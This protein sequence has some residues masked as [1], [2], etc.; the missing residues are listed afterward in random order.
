MPYCHRMATGQGFEH[1]DLLLPQIT[2]HVKYLVPP[3]GK[4]LRF[5]PFSHL[6]GISFCY[7]LTC[8]TPEQNQI[9]LPDPYSFLPA[10]LPRMT[11]TCYQSAHFIITVVTYHYCPPVRTDCMFPSL[12]GLQIETRPVTPTERAE[13]FWCLEFTSYFVTAPDLTPTSGKGQITE[14]LHQV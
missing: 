12:P 6:V 1:S 3:L 4:H 7:F 5:Q 14:D 13:I 9:Y 11:K 8:F 2:P 10:A